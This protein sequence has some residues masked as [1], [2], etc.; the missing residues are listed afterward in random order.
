[1]RWG[2]ALRWGDGV[3][4]RVA[5]T[6]GWAWVRDCGS[7]AASPCTLFQKSDLSFWCMPPTSPAVATSATTH[8]DGP[9]SEL[10]QALYDDMIDQKTLTQPNGLAL[11]LGG[12]S[13]D[14]GP[15][16]RVKGLCKGRAEAAYHRHAAHAA[17]HGPKGYRRQPWWTNL[18]ADGGRITD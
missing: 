13:I 7:A 17:H 16:T 12:G 3:W 14:R 10:L 9:A 18:P 4:Q 8:A 1:M 15:S 11:S 6:W 2:V 5:L